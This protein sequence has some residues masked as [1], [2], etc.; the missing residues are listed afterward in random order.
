MPVFNA[1]PSQL[2]GTIRNNVTRPLSA[3]L[4]PENATTAPA[5]ADTEEVEHIL[6]ETP[7]FR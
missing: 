4:S 1:N 7:V 3:L 2:Q 6:P 5:G